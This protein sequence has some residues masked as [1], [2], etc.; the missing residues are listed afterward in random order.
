[1]LDLGEV[2]VLAGAAAEPVENIEAGCLEVR[3]RVVALGDEQLEPI[4]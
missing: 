3:R 2:E 1:V 4:L